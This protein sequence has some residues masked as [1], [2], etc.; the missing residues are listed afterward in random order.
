MELSLLGS[1]NCEKVSVC[2]SYTSLNNN[3]IT[4]EVQVYWD[5]PVYGEH[6]ELRA[7]RVDPR[8]VNNRD[9]Q[10]IA[11]EMSCPWVSNR[12]KRTSEKTMKYAHFRW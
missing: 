12:D 7:K 5:V 6:Q 11:L 10:V 3:N 2:Y 4:A 1:S 9:K 8:I